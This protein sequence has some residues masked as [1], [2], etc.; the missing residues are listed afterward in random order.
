MTREDS[1]GGASFYKGLEMIRLNSAVSKATTDQNDF[2]KDSP[3]GTQQT[4]DLKPPQV[5]A[6]SADPAYDISL[7][8]AQFSNHHVDAAAPIMQRQM[9]SCS[10]Q[11]QP[12]PNVNHPMTREPSSAD[13]HDVIR[14]PSSD[15]SYKEAIKISPASSFTRSSSSK[16][17]GCPHQGCISQLQ[18]FKGMHEMQRHFDRAHKKAR[19]VY[20]CAPLEDEPEFLSKPNCKGCQN[21]KRYNEDYNAGEHLRRMHFNPKPPKVRRGQLK[22][23]EKRGGKG[24]GTE[25]SMTIL[26]NYMVTFE[27]DVNGKRVSEPRRVNPS[28]NLIMP[29]ITDG[30]DRPTDEDSAKAASPTCPAETDLEH[31]NAEAKSNAP[32]FAGNELPGF[33]PAQFDFAVDLNNP[34][35]DDPPLFDA[36]LLDNSA[37]YDDELAGLFPFLP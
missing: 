3:T 23:E 18:G 20:V 5:F 12:K 31:S 17:V 4:P 7:A 9:S 24:G 32:W 10:R 16:K 2:R 13:G 15:G 27:V 34:L 33:D 28:S 25:P 29:T 1:S 30:S 6:P 36:N 21:Q 8:G 14:V 35:I 11:L 37:V 26:R 22:P 19:Q